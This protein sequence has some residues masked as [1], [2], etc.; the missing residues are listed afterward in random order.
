MLTTLPVGWRRHRRSRFT[1]FLACLL[2]L[3]FFSA[4]LLAQQ[5][6]ALAYTFTTLAGKPLSGSA[7]GIG[8]AAQFHQPYGIAIGNAGD[9]YVADTFNF[10]IRKVTSAGVVTTIAGV[11]GVFGS[12]DGQGSNARFNRPQGIAVNNAGNI[13]VADTGNHTIRAISPSGEVRTIAGFPGFPG[14]SDIA[15]LFSFPSGLAVD[16]ATNL[17]VADTGNHTIRKI[18]AEGVVTTL[19]GLAGVS[20][21]NNGTGGNARFASPSGIAVDPAG[22]LYVADSENQTIRKI[23][24]AGNVVSTLAG[25]PGLRGTNDGPVASARFSQPS[26]ICVDSGTNLYV[27]DTFNTTIRRISTAGIV[28]TLAGLPA[29]FGSVDGTGNGARFYEPYGIAADVQGNLYVADTY[30]H[31][32]RKVTAA[33]ITTTLAGSVANNVFNPISVD[34]TGSNARFNKP[35]AIAADNIGNLY[36]ADT[37]NHTIR[38]VTAAGVV[39]TFAGVAGSP[40]ANNGTGS[41][42]RF[43]GPSAIAVDNAG[44]LYVAETNHVIRK[45]TL[46]GVVATL[47]GVA[48]S[49]GTN[50]GSGS[51]ARFNSPYGIA[52]DGAGTVYVA[53]SENNTIRKI[54]PAGAT[55]TMAGSPGIPGT[56]NGLGNNARFSHPAGIAVDSATNVYVADSY[57]YTIRKITVSGFVSTIAGFAGSS[58]IDDGV[59]TNAR[60]FPL[61]GL[62]VDSLGNLYAADAYNATI[63]KITP[64]SVVSTVGGLAGSFGSLDGTGNSAQFDEP[65]GIALDNAGN[66]YVADT[67]NNTIRKGVFTA[68][69][70]A[71]KVAYTVPPMSGNL[72][73]TLLPLEA[74]GQWRFPWEFGWRNSGVTVSNLVAGNYPIEFR[75]VPGFLVLPVEPVQVTAGNMTTITNIYLPTLGAEDTNSAPGSLTVFLGPTP[76]SGAGWRF[77]GDSGPFFNTGFTT[78]LSPGTYLIEFAAVSGRVK[79]PSQS[80]QIN[81]GLPSSLSVNYL[82]AAT[83]PVNLYLPFP[84][85]DDQVND[86]TTYPFGFNGQ[87]Q[88]DTGYGSGVAVN[89]NVVLTAAH[90][91]FNDQTLSYVSR[92]HW[93]FRRQAGVQ[94]P[95]PQ[96]ARGFYLLSGYAAQ[97]TN[98]LFSGST[99]DQSTP[100]SRNLDVAALYFTLPVA[101]GGHGGYLPSDSVP[102]TWLSGTTL[103]MLVGYPVDGSQFGTNLSAGKMYQT[104]PQP[105]PLNLSTDPVPGSQQVYI[106]PWFLSYPG[107]SGGPLYVQLNGNYYYPAGVYIGTLFSGAQP[108]ASVV[109]A[110]DSSVVNLITLAASQ[111]DNGTNNTGGGVVTIVPSQNV[112]AMH[113]G[114]VQFQ[115]APPAAVRAGAAWRLLGDTAFSTASNYTRIVTSTN[116]FGVEFKSIPG[117]NVPGSQNVAVVADQLTP[118]TAFYTVMNPT[119]C[120]GDSALLG[121]IGTTGTTYRLENATTL[122]DATWLPIITNI[123]RTNGFNP[124]LTNPTP[125]FYRLNWLT[126]F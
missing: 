67:V 79:P 21:T 48:G 88:S 23:T 15:K 35:F 97:R 107:N 40:G 94:E 99:P 36:V 121:M 122:T 24:V 46:A 47:A 5:N 123:I 77:L 9:L 73:V 12:S 8:D 87:L 69:G 116:T 60:F 26:G 91:V 84:V 90:L 78:N 126:N 70:S 76:P 39:S 86:E 50:D 29:N 22:N 101:G 124:I 13:Y 85:Q 115:L 119:L 125:G 92:A 64:S 95:L 110:I 11:P 19:A 89:T 98:D 117:W 45:I 112:N 51:S 2:C 61:E 14:S 96:A 62:A 38:K 30:N 7:D 41:A 120:I 53:D 49:R 54:T 44:T 3:G 114:Y 113:A 111:G 102:N 80:V 71:N 100:P 52:V 65:H 6:S 4:R 103:K 34:A 105:Y 57:N 63:R 72:T 68:Y 17:Y 37:G 25:S 82:L 1:G 108:Y 118:Y 109:R 74:G 28:S 20:G 106:A 58:G 104:D 93:F 42:A 31:T 27:A 59:G 55:S 75:N 33:G 66:L 81:A 83:P 56:A 32:I 10:T 43:N 18:T 16:S